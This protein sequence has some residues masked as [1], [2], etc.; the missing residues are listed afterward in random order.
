MCHGR[1]YFQLHNP[2]DSF[3]SPCHRNI[4]RQFCSNTRKLM[5]VRV[6]SD[7][8]NY[9][10]QHLQN[11]KSLI[12]YVGFTFGIVACCDMFLWIEEYLPKTKN[13]S[14]VCLKM[15]Q[16]GCLFV[17]NMRWILLNNG[18]LPELVHWTLQ[19]CICCQKV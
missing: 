17:Y 7:D 9:E 8:V 19:W 6:S 1:F 14:V 15:I 10:Y 5:H 18:Y 13:F 12:C 3:L 2:G 4:R 11:A 16:F